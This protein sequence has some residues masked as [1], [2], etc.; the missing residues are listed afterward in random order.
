MPVIALVGEERHSGR[1]APHPLDGLAGMVEE[2]RPFPRHD[3]PVAILEV[4]DVVGERRQRDRVGAEKHFALAETDRERRPVAGADDH[5]VMVGEQHCKR[6]GAFQALQRGEH[7]GLRIVPLLQEPRYQLG[8]HLGIGL[9]PELHAFG[10]EFR[11]QLC[12]VLDD[13]VVNH[14][15]IAGEMRM[16]VV[17]RRCAV[18]GPAGVADTDRS[19]ERIVPE[20]LLEP[21]QLAFC[22]PAVKPP[23]VHRRHACRIVAAV[24]EPLQRIDQQRCHVTAADNSDYA[25]HPSSP[26]RPVSLRS[27]PV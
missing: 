16:G 15:D 6:I 18:G 25:A 1:L 5:V 12:E 26:V 24:F 22:A 17:F 9:G 23:M 3:G 20:A 10:D 27:W 8:D 4:G 7:G 13:A 19:G 14:A 11:L 21:D 2:F